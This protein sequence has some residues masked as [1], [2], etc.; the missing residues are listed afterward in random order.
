M[1]DAPPPTP[2]LRLAETRHMGPI[3]ALLNDQILHGRAHFGVAT[4]PPETVLAQW[5]AHRERYPWIVAEDAS[6]RFLGFARAHSWRTRE[7]Y[8]WTAETAIYIE[9]HARG[10]GVGRALYRCL[11]DTLRRQ[12]F[13]VVLAGMTVPNPAS[14]RLHESMGMTLVGEIT[15]AGYKLG[16]WMAVRYYQMVLRDLT[17]DE[18]PGVVRP[19]SAVWV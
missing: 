17:G 14:Q 12:G 9:P 19:V 16:R 7:A 10:T 18:D 4:E 6:G 3:A 5:D 11:F 8:D 15:P 1:S 2:G 13:V